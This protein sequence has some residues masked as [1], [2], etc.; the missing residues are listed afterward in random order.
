MRTFETFDELW[1]DAARYTMG[2]G[3][4]I[5]SRDGP[6]REVLG[7]TAKL[8][9]TSYNF[10]FNPHR[11]MRPDYAAA[12]LLW[13]LSGDGSVDM[14][15]AYAP[16]YVRFAN[17]GVV[18]GAYGVRIGQQITE[19]VRLL[20]DKPNTRQAVISLWND[21]DLGDAHTGQWNDLPCTLTLT[22]MLRDGALNMLV[23][24]RS[25]DLWFGL[26]YDLFCWTSI[27]QLVA[28]TL[29]VD[30]GWYQHSAASLHCYEKHW[31][32]VM[33][34]KDADF[35]THKLNYK[36]RPGKYLRDDIT[37]AVAMEIW[38]R[39]NKT[40]TQHLSARLGIGTMLE[41]IVIMAATKWTG[42]AAARLTNKELRGLC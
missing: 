16:S 22:F 24:M 14:I 2:Q 41:Q 30:V 38:N 31:K 18:H 39:N 13:Y 4:N 33:V 20:Q 32:R 28:S 11:N 7:Y 25:N 35:A 19:L 23:N 9:D 27:Q 1:V 6:C 21:T 15:S 26:P 3:A 40:C 36:S 10:L 29:E 42:R 34:A 12:E 5:E 8:T 37:T 17:D